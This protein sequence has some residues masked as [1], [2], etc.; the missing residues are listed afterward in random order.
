MLYLGIE[1]EH[2]N[3]ISGGIDI[4]AVK[5]KR[6][7]LISYTLANLVQ[8]ATY[9]ATNEQKCTTQNAERHDTTLT[10]GA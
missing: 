7:T 1:K 9:K 4:I 3:G 5:K 2:R 10:L 6:I 8:T